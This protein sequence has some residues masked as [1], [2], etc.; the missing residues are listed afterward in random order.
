MVRTKKVVSVVPCITEA[1]RPRRESGP[2]VFINSV[3]IPSTA[4]PERGRIIARGNISD[5][6]PTLL[7]RA[8]TAW[9]KASIAPEARNTDIATIIPTKNGMILTAVVN[10]SSAPS[11]KAS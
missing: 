8:S 10:P 7:V 11:T 2:W 9:L 1:R 5:G 4:L 6:I 3:A